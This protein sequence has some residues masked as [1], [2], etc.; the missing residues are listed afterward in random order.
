MW[1][2]EMFEWKR[3]PLEMR[4]D[5]LKQLIAEKSSSYFWEF[6]REREISIDKNIESV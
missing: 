1:P 3:K 6:V 5:E 4:E 2:K